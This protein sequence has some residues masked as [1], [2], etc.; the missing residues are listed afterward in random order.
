MKKVKREHRCGDTE[1]VRN[2][3]LFP[4]SLFTSTLY[5]HLYTIKVWK[6]DLKSRPH[7]L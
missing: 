7:G 2:K 1:R 5:L 4:V 3:L 6:K